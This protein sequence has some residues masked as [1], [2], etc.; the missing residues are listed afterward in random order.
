MPRALTRYALTDLLR[1]RRDLARGDAARWMAL[2]V[3]SLALA[4]VLAIVLVVGH[5][6][7]L[8]RSAPADPDIARRTLVVHVVLA[9]FVWHVSFLVGLFNLLPRPRRSLRGAVASR[10]AILGLIA[11]AISVSQ[12]SAAPIL[13]NYIPVL[14]SQLFLAGLAIFTGAAT[15]A[16]VDVR[17]VAYRRDPTDVGHAT[18]A[19]ALTFLIA[20]LTVL[21]A[22][23]TDPGASGALR[24][25]RLFWGGGHILQTSATMAMLTVWLALTHRVTGRHALGPRA[26]ALLFALMLAPTLAGPWLAMS[27][28]PHPAFTTLMELGL[29]PFVTAVAIAVVL[30]M[31]GV[32]MRWSPATAGLATSAGMTVLGF[33]FAAGIAND[34]TLVPAH[35]H[36]NIGAVTVS[37]M[38]FL[39]VA[40]PHAVMTRR[41]RILATVQPVIYGVGQATFA[42]GL[43]IAGFWGGAARKSY[44]PEQQIDGS[45]VKTGFILAGVGGALALVGG[46]LF[47]ALVVRAWTGRRRFRNDDIVVE[48]MTSSPAPVAP[49]A[50]L[51]R[52]DP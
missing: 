44:G 4:G 3:L 32:R 11:M 34:T 25:E 51:R 37:F 43:G 20:V 28:S 6:P 31:R 33:V 24:Y 47:V 10:I 38:T 41:V 21:C 30:A 5:I 27:A 13:S 39:L 46:A 14:D 40:P 8:A 48:M 7:A 50:V 17:L 18:R 1:R 23:L 36:L 26:G 35:Y 45:V 19:A 2:G 9:A 49:G 29:F 15:L 16:V 52:R 42:T 22:C 12:R